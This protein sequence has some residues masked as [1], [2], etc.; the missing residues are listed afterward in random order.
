MAR[1]KKV[2]VMTVVLER[3]TI[4]LVASFRDENDDL[5]TPQAIT[6]TLTDGDGNVINSREDQSVSPAN[7]ITIVLSGDDLSL[8]SG[9]DGRRQ[10]VIHGTYDGDLGA[11]LP[12]VGLLEFTVRNI[13]GVA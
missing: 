13:P 9:D 3:S 6:W 12:V 1:K 11:D 4:A 2:R 5:V 10:V 8:A 7:T